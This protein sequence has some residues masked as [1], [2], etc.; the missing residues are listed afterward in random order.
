MR[1]VITTL[2][3][4]LTSG[5]AFAHELT[6]TYPKLRQSIY[7]NVLVTNIT[8]FNRREDINYYSIE[9]W[10]ENWESVPFATSSKVIQ[11]NYLERKNVELFFRISDRPRVKYICTRSKILETNET[12]VIASNICSK[13]K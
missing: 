11:L 6:P 10:D 4:A 2:L 9:I 8:M 12:S 7:D 1:F 5:L 13:V 3:W